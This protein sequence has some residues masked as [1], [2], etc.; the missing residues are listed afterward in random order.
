MFCQNSVKNMLNTSTLIK[1]PL[2]DLVHVYKQLININ[3]L[4]GLVCDHISLI[5]LNTITATLFYVIHCSLTSLW[6]KL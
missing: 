4:L 6:E 2:N 3:T 1:L 5:L